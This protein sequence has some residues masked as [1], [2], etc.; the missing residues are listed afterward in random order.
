MIYLKHFQKSTR[1][2]LMA[3]ILSVSQIS[4]ITIYGMPE[5]ADSVLTDGDTATDTQMSGWME[6]DGKKYY[7]SP[8]TGQMLT[9]LQQIEGETYYFLL[10]T[11]EMQVG[12]CIIGKNEFYFSPS[13][14]RLQKGL[15]EIEGDTYYLSEDSGAMMSGWQKMN[16]KRYYFLKDSGV[17]L[18]GKQKIDGRY[19]YFSEENGAMQTGWQKIDGKKYYAGSDGRLVSGWKKIGGWKYYFLPKNNRM[20][21]GTYKIGKVYYIFDSQGRLSKADG[22]HVVKVGKNRYLA[23]AGGKAASGWQMVDN[24]FYYASK[25]GK[26]KRNTTYKGVIFTDTGAAKNST[27][28]QA[29]ITA[30]QVLNSITNSGMTKE[31]KLNACWTYVTSRNFRYAPKYPNLNA[32]GWQRQTAFDM[33]TTKTGNCYSF[34]CAFAALASEIGYQPYVVCGKVRGSRDRSSDGYTRHAWVRING[35]NYDPEGQY[36]GWMRGIYGRAAYP[37]GHTIQSIVQY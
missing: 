31:Q 25:T 36:A 1:V 32:G 26:A 3:L 20:V 4:S 22:V 35:L 27:D 23:G 17:M 33:L 15:C 19:Y 12:F 28:V 10:E 9:G 14:G 5:A 34:A 16:G 11:G 6:R 29:A 18:Y 24:K 21:T 2:L 8:E 30:R 13:D 37:I 7:V